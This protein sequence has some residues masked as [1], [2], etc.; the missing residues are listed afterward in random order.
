VT[1]EEAAIAL[2]ME[3]RAFD[4]LVAAHRDI[5]TR[6]MKY[7]TKWLIPEVYLEELSQNRDFPL[8]KWKYELLAKRVG[9]MRRS[10][11]VSHPEKGSHRQ[12]DLHAGSG[13][14]SSHN[15]TLA[16]M[17]SDITNLYGYP[18]VLT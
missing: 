14:K 15:R 6:I 1:I 10:T 4:L 12:H 3:Q 18:L 5:F 9:R 2:G 8:L 11:P 17:A 16:Q 13:P 7:D